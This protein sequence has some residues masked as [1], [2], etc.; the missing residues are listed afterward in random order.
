MGGD[1]EPNT[2]GF[3]MH[4]VC[5]APTLLEHGNLLAGHEQVRCTVG[6]MLVL[7]HAEEETQG[8]D[9]CGGVQELPDHRLNGCGRGAPVG[10]GL[11]SGSADAE[12]SASWKRLE[13]IEKE[14][15]LKGKKKAEGGLRARPPAVGDRRQDR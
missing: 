6:H 3:A 12:A 4:C 14:E 7:G 13:E 8:T 9:A 11:V 10:G 15:E 1:D 2:S 5:Q